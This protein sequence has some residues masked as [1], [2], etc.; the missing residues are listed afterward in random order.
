M[1]KIRGIDKLGPSLN[2][3][4]LCLG[5]AD[6]GDQSVV[7][8]LGANEGARGIVAPQKIANSQ[9]ALNPPATSS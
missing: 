4:V 9:P 7:R 8:L 6:E 3:S 5:E 1:S 2:H